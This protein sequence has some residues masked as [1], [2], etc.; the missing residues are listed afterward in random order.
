MKSSGTR[1]WLILWKA[2][3]TLR[4][5]AES[6]IRSLG[7]CYSDFAVLEA[8]LHKGPT[9][10]NTIGAK[11]GLT[12]G[13]ITAAVDRL[14]LKGLVERREDAADRRARMVHLTAAGRKL[15]SAAFAEH[16][17]AMQRATAGL[18]PAERAQAAELLK[19]LGLAARAML[20]T[21]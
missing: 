19:K 7:L 2:Y 13:S 10:V 8:L 14:A 21:R 17:A 9:P 16:V 4:E 18:T 15:A 3:G 11:V 20:E 6:H 1:L 12:S 5:C